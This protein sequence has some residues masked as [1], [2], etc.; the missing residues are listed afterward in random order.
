MNLT[1]AK[2]SQAASLMKKHGLDCWIIQF[3]RETGLRPDPLGYLVGAAVTWPSAFLL[4]QDGR[5]AAI[6]GSG[7]SGQIQGLGFWDEVR[8]YVASPREDLVVLL[9]SWDPKKIG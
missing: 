6:V 8:P 5:T 3:A 7:D 4:N 9:Q 1:R 2:L